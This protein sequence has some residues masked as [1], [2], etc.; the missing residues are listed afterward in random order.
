MWRQSTYTIAALLLLLFINLVLSGQLHEHCTYVV[1]EL[2]VDS[3]EKLLPVEVN[4]LVFADRPA[5]GFGST[6]RLNHEG[7]IVSVK[8][9][10]GGT[11]SVGKMGLTPAWARSFVSWDS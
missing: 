9:S 7:L 11:S 10:A 5:V 4:A 2:V 1:A 3:Q 6:A 8:S